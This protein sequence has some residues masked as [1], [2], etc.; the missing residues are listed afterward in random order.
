MWNEPQPSV[1]TGTCSVLGDYSLDPESTNQSIS[2]SKVFP[3]KPTR[4]TALSEEWGDVPLLI[5]PLALGRGD[6]NTQQG[7]AD[8]AKDLAYDL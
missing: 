3:I 6:I 4:A 5:V 8:I 1:T 7:F 2:C